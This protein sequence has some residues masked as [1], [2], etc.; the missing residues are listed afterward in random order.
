MS[1]NQKSSSGQ[2]RSTKSAVKPGAIGH[3][4]RGNVFDDPA[5]FDSTRGA[6]LKMRATALRGLQ[7]WLADSGLT[8]DAAAKLLGVTQARVSDL[9]RGKI[10]A[11][12]L[13]LLVRFAQ[14]AGLHPE[15]RLA[16]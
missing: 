10:T 7:R 11:F 14:R 1:R 15:L 2:R 9:K 4:T 8:Q 6:E 13:D 12:S 3:V 16:A 5:L